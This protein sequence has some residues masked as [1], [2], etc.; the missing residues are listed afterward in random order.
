MYAGPKFSAAQEAEMTEPT[1][2][3]ADKIEQQQQLI[4]P[5]EGEEEDGL[6]DPGEANPADAAEQSHDIV[7]PADIDD[8]HEHAHDLP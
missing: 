7:D 6:I 5:P 1:A 2:D 8:E 4:P 3:E